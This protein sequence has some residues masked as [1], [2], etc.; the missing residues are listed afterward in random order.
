KKDEFVCDCSDIDDV[1]VI[2]KD[3]SMQV[4]RI[5]DK[6][7]VGKDIL[8]VDVFKKNNVRKIYNLMYLDG[9]TGFTYMK[10]FFVKSITR[11]KSYFLGSEHPKSKITYFTANKNGEAE[12]VSIQ[13]KTGTSAKKK[14]KF[15][16]DF[17]ELAIKSR[18]AKGN[19]VSKHPVRKI[20]LKQEGLSTLDPI[21]IWF[22]ESV[23]RIN[24]DERGRLLGEFG[25]SEQIIEFLPTGQ[26]KLHGMDISA[27]FDRNLVQIEKL[28]PKKPISVI[29]YNEEKKKHFVKRFLA[30]TSSK[31]V[32]FLPDEHCKLISLSTDWRPQIELHFKKK[33]NQ[34][35]REPESIVLDEFIAVKGLK[36]IGNQLSSHDIKEIKVLEP[37]EHITEI[38]EDNT[39]SVDDNSEDIDQQATLFD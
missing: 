24:K 32:D 27:H 17:A 31:P 16:V 18:S 20:E 2:R 34:D 22:D 12:L 14:L 9:K 26:Y 10:R 8:Y 6:K 1:I 39:E 30:E 21:K 19:L 5:D 36:A 37:L 13:L 29:Y 33:R 7:F 15:D 38:Q 4:T 25:P 11:D 3:G 35:L 23:M 28:D